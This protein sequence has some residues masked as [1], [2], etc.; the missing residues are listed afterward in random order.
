MGALGAD[1]YAVFPIL[2]GLGQRVLGKSPHESANFASTGADRSVWEFNERGLGGWVDG[3]NLVR[4]VEMVL[5]SGMIS[6]IMFSDGYAFLLVHCCVFCA[7][8]NGALPPLFFGMANLRASGKNA[9]VRPR[10][11][12]GLMM[13]KG[14]VM[15]HRTVAANRNLTPRS[16]CGGFTL[17]ELLVVIAII[18]VLIAALLPAL[19]KA[20]KSARQTVSL[21][22]IRSITSAAAVYQ[23]DQKGYMPMMGIWGGGGFYGPAGRNQDSPAFAG[24]CTWSSWGKTTSS[25]WLTSQALFDIRASDRM[26]NYYLY[27]NLVDKPNMTGIAVRAQSNSTERTDLEMPGFKDPSDRI[28]HQRNWP[29]GNTPTGSDVLSCYDDVGTSYQWQAKWWYQCLADPSLAGVRNNWRL[30]FDAGMRRFRIADSFIPSRLVWVNDEWADITMTRPEGAAVKNGYDDINKAVLGFMDAHAAYLPI[31]TGGD[32]VPA[33]GDFMSV[34]A[35]NN[36]KY[37]TIFPFGR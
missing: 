25:Y 7:G 24:W 37:C 23:A 20:R 11:G 31:I 33:N 8:M 35:Y 17:I 3:W 30:V 10:Y 16:R 1:F 27:P 28:G 6:A 19:G 14:C 22:N 2:T 26:L 18:A 15:F 12:A 5:Q 4:F 21:A 29:A 9:V 32:G 13:M 34:P 36:E